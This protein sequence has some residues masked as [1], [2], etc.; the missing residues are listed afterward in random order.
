[1]TDDGVVMNKIKYFIVFL[2][3][4]YFIFAVFKLH[5]LEGDAAYSTNSDATNGTTHDIN[6]NAIDFNLDDYIAQLAQDLGIESNNDDDSDTI[7]IRKIKV[8]IEGSTKESWVLSRLFIKEGD[9]FTESQWKQKSIDQAAYF[10]ETGLFYNANIY[11]QALEEENEFICI[12]DLTDGYLYTYNFWPWDFSLGFRH[13]LDA[14]EYLN[15]T[16]GSTTQYVYWSHPVIGGTPLSYAVGLGHLEKKTSGYEHEDFFKA[17]GLLYGSFGPFINT[18]LESELSYYKIPDQGTVSK[19]GLFLEIFPVYRYMQPFGFN[20]YTSSGLI[21][22]S[23]LN[24]SWYAQF[25]SVVV[26]RPISWLITELGL[27]SSTTGHESP[28]VSLPDTSSY[29]GPS[30]LL[31]Q[32]TFIRSFAQISFLSVVSK[33]LGFTTMTINPY[34]FID[35]AGSFPSIKEIDL[36]STKTSIG[37]AIAVGFSYPVGL[38]FSFGVKKGIRPIENMSFHFSVDINLY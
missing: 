14:D 6:N 36:D 2:V 19:L 9:I 21:L 20:A 5:A 32:N 13:L 17:E 11:I 4:V 33:P 23:N 1:M 16:L 8:K 18:G 37:S 7:I 34:T 24:K 12:V 25:N 31:K 35:I 10:L 29:R 26:F 3:L 38:Y 28:F 22:D 27:E 15:L 30:V